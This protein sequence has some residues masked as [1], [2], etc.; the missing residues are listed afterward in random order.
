M[1]SPSR[2]TDPSG[3]ARTASTTSGMRSPI[4]SSVRV[5]TAMSSPSRCTW[6][7]TPSSFHSTAAGST[8]CNAP[9]SDGA[10]L[11]SIGCTGRPT[12]RWKRP[13]PAAPSVRAAWATA[14]RSPASIAA[15]RTAAGS[16]PAAAATASV[17]MPASA[18]WRSSPPASIARKRCSSAVARANSCASS[19]RRT[20][21]EPGPV[22]ASMR[23]NARSTSATSRLAVA[24]G[25]GRSRR[26]AQPTPERRWRSSPDR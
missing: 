1:A 6:M 13:S 4:G 21:L 8:C 10:V 5:K 24:A 23:A 9:S 19:S 16:T 12:C 2:M 25:G 17:T 15:L 7:R 3:S 26:A 14:G 18:P 20:A 22:A 11:A